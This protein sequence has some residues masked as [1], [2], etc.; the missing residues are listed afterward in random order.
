MR[1]FFFKPIL[2]AVKL[3]YVPLL[4]GIFFLIVGLIVLN[5]PLT[6]LAALGLL[7]S[8]SFIFAGV[9]EI[10]F[11]IN[12]RKI[13]ENW[14]WGLILGIFTFLVGLLL[15]TN[16]SLS[17]T[18]LSLYIGFLILFRSIAGISFSL[19]LKRFGRKNWG[20]I[21]FSG[22]LGSIFAFILLWHPMIAGIGAVFFVAM[23]FIMTAVFNIVFSFQ[24]RK[25]HRRSKRISRKLR[26]RYHSLQQEI[27]DVYW[28]EV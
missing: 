26:D 22:I 8:I 17:V 18:T 5:S 28:E 13:L 23:S 7:F 6:S 24:L 12:N 20:W 4:G 19:D 15:I 2:D 11:S 3:W 10:I 25:I 14:G 16:L 9:L 1:T 27:E 21:L